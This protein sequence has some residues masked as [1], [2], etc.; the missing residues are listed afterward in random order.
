MIFNNVRPRPAFEGHAIE[1]RPLQS[2]VETGE[3]YRAFLSASLGWIDNQLLVAT[4]LV[5]LQVSW[6]T[7]I[8]AIHSPQLFMS[9]S[10][11]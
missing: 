3:F 4:K 2:S 5:I 11:Y 6:C 9:A 10:S 1:R 7:C 8:G